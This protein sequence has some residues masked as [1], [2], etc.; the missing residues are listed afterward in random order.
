MKAMYWFG[1][2]LACAM[3]VSA[4]DSVP[5]SFNYQGVLRD[6]S[7]GYLPAGTKTVAFRLYTVASGSD[8]A[9]WGR[10][11]SVLL[12]TNGLFNVSLN[13]TVGGP[14]SN[15]APGA[16]SAL[17]DVIAANAKLYMGVQV[18]GSA[19]EIA[20]RQQLLS[21]PFAL[22]AGDVRKTSGGLTVN[23]ALTVANG[24]KVTGTIQATDKIEVGAS[25][26]ATL[27]ASSQGALVVPSLDA[28]G[29]MTVAGKLD[30]TGKTTVSNLTAGAAT[31]SNLTV[32]GQVS[33]LSANTQGAGW[34]DLATTNGIPLITTAP[35]DGFLV[36][37]FW[38]AFKTVT[39]GTLVDVYFHCSNIFPSERVF[40]YGFVPQ[41]L[42]YWCSKSDIITIPVLKGETVKMTAT[43]TKSSDSS[44]QYQYSYMPF[45]NRK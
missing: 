42:N 5:P 20:P 27:T 39:S 31:V 16:N 24:M 18:S 28:S 37:N 11:C 14:A 26:K 7:G 29:N 10:E 33:I 44:I 21:V 38:S 35:S 9:I 25:A 40:R 32:N 8:K 1:V 30:V 6:G 41:P 15:L 34:T 4:L 17:L 43:V 36:V 45:G 13:D 19:G 12:D 3:T 2:V 22:M 23:G